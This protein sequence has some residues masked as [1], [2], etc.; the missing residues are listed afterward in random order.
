MINVSFSINFS[1]S[2]PTPKQT[3][4]KRL[5]KRLPGQARL[6]KRSGRAKIKAFD[7]L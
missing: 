1:Y 3:N 6:L 4:I 7:R 5:L 2:V